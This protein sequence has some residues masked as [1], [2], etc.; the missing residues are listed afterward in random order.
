[1]TLSITAIAIGGLIWL[2]LACIIAPIIGKIIKYH[3]P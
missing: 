3:K 2:A 1:M